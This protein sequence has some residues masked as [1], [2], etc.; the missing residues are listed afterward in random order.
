MTYGLRRRLAL[1]FGLLLTVFVATA[2]F[3]NHHAQLGLIESRV[4]S[5]VEH[6][7]KLVAAVTTS[8]LFDMRIADLE[9]HWG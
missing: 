2:V 3:I 5:H 9:G 6:F 4:D 7:G 8:Y 1:V